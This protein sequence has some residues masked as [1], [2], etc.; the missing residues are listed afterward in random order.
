MKT[1]YEKLGLN[2]LALSDHDEDI[3]D[4]GLANLLLYVATVID[5]GAFNT[6]SRFEEK[7]ELDKVWL[8]RKAASRLAVHAES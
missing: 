1:N 7:R 5:R 6:G 2:T 3:T 4:E 8:L